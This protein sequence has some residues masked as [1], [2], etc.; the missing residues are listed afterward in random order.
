MVSFARVEGVDS[1]TENVRMSGRF[2]PESE[3]KIKPTVRGAKLCLIC[4]IDI[5]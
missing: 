3:V 4:I 1:G 2:G 5:S